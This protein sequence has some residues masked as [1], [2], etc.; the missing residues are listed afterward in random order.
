MMG[1]LS[2]WI[3][4]TQYTVITKQLLGTLEVLSL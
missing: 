3:E 4:L 2:E 1:L